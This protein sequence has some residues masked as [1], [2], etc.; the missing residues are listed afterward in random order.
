M[1]LYDLQQDDQILVELRQDSPALR[2]YR[3]SQKNFYKTNKNLNRYESGSFLKAEGS[4]ISNSNKVITMNFVATVNR[5]KF[6]T[7]EI[8]YISIRSLYLFEGETTR[9]FADIQEPGT[10]R[11]PLKVY[12]TKVKVVW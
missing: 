8:D 1:T 11:V 10:G 5:N 7:A 9:P 12:R 6:G 3:K 2:V 4:V